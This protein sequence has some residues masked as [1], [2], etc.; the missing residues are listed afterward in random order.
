MTHKVL[1]YGM[2]Y[3]PEMAGVGRY[4][5]EIAEHLAAE[6]K[7]VVVV[8]TPAHYPGWRVQAPYRN[9]Y[10]TET[11]NGVTVVRCPLLLRER[12]EGVWRLIAPISFAATSL[13][14]VLWQFIRHRPDTLLCIEPTLIAAPAALLA[15]KL[16][17]ARSILHVQDLEVDAAFAVGHLGSKTWLKRLGYAFERV[18]MRGFDRVVTISNRMAEKI[19]EKGVPEARVSV[20][21]NW[22]D[23]DQ[24]F[25][26]DG[27][28]PYRQELGY[29]DDD[30]VV[31][32]SGNIG[33]KQGLHVLLD[34]AERLAGD[35]S[36]RFVIAGEGPAK[37][38]LVARYGKLDTV[39][40]LPFQPYE[41]L[42]AFLN[43]ADLH[44][45]PQDA[46]AADLVLP[47]KLGGMLAS[48]RP[49]VVTAASG[50]EIFEFLGQAAFITPPGDSEKLAE[51]I[52]DVARQKLTTDRVL[53]SQLSAQLSRSDGLK[54]FTEA[55]ET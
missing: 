17:G 32:Y 29:A 42:N 22:V 28:S 20:I 46:N 18:V 44:A 30:F 11:L 10:Q 1:V 27:P 36:I 37:T 2:N 13:P 25:P 3:A 45:L 41:R 7:S 35:R 23:L 55:L 50:T 52:R 4:T 15:A 43:M 39:R 38:D 31:L 9:A 24:I 40:F 21:R 12:M 14:A 48:G 8:T 47:S 16:T 33:A 53:Q 49:I 34:A 19:A 54:R 51:A 5:G 6:G 26:L